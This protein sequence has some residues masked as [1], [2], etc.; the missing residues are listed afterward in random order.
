MV[1]HAF[2]LNPRNYLEDCLRY[3]L[4]NLWTTG[5]PWKVVNSAIS[6][7]LAYEPPQGAKDAWIN[8]TG[9]AWD[10]LEDEMH[11][12][13]KCPKCHNFCNIPWTTCGLPEKNTSA[14]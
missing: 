10:N 7:Q 4:K 6:T 9:R 5:M 12:K 8:A 3:G 1:W 2:M 11:V 14:W 13:V